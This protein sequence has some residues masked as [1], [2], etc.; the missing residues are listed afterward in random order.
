MF[1]DFLAS[2]TGITNVTQRRGGPRQSFRVETLRTAVRRWSKISGHAQ[3]RR[4][5]DSSNTW[6]DETWFNL[7]LWQNFIERLQ[8]VTHEAMTN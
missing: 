2:L 6:Q 4:P 5:Q 1:D 8:H 3:F 7:D